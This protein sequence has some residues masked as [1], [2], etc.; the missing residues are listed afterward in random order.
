M[1]V[2]GESSEDDESEDADD[3]NLLTVERDNISLK[4]K[5]DEINK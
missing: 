1:K 5:K 2:D 4:K 3:S